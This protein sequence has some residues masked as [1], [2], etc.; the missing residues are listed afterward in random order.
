M[1]GAGMGDNRQI[2]I[3]LVVL[4]ITFALLALVF[5]LDLLGRPVEVRQLPLVDPEFLK[6]ET[7]RQSYAD[8]VK[9]EEDLDAFDCYACHEEGVRQE[10]KF[11]D[12]QQLVIP[13]EHSD[14]EMGHGAHGRNNNCFNCH[15]DVNL[16]RLQSRDGHELK[17]EES[18]QLCGSCHGPTKEDWDAGAH[19]R[20]NGFWSRGQGPSTRLDCV[21]C[22][23]PHSPRF[24]GRKPAP[25]P[26]HLRERGRGAGATHTED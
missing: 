22:H 18:S 3:V 23:D 25:A 11:D 13:D 1:K 2:R 14:I 21:N 7:W 26:N 4:S 19:G 5:S 15:N 8:L 20:I 16:L 6:T 17:F 24:P 9:A 10:L 12:K